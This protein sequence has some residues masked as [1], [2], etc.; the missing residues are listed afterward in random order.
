MDMKKPGPR[1]SRQLSFELNEKKSA[2]CADSIRNP[3][4]VLK[5][6]DSNTLEV[7]QQALARVASSGIFLSKS[8][9][10]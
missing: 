6:V 4:S 9:R 8:K 7:R 5:F 3:T 10:K 1:K 2:T